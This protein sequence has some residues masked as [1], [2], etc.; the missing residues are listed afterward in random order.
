MLKVYF[1]A[2]GAL[3]RPLPVDEASYLSYSFSD[4]STYGGGA[5][6]SPFL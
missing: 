4:E 2:G 1:C 6:K 5:K 3:L